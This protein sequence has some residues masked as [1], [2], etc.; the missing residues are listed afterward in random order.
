VYPKVRRLLDLVLGVGLGYLIGLVVTASPLNRKWAALGLLLMLIVAVFLHLGNRWFSWA[1]ALVIGLIFI[2]VLWQWNP[3]GIQE[4]ATLSAVAGTPTKVFDGDL[5]VYV[6][7]I[8][9]GTMRE[10][11]IQGAR[12]GDVCTWENDGGGIYSYRNE[13]DGAFRAAVEVEENN[14]DLDIDWVIGPDV[15]VGCQPAE[16]LREAGAITVEV[17]KH[18]SGPPALIIE[19]QDESLAGAACTTDFGLIGSDE[20]SGGLYASS[21]GIIAGPG[22]PRTEIKIPSDLAEALTASTDDVFELQFA[23]WCSIP[24]VG[25][26][27]GFLVESG[28]L[29]LRSGS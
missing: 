20:T 19:S 27:D 24:D 4:T 17:V 8:A 1:S 29:S 15:E 25:A 5:V 18:P 11:T 21:D 13:G 14:V 12:S 3:K 2:G 7:G 23:T 26:G 16:T 28:S 22:L 10:F 9:N 6:D